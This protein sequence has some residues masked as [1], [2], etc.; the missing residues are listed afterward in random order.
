[1]P[2][3]L[4]SMGCDACVQACALVP[5]RVATAVHSHAMVLLHACM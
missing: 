3:L 1:M 2:A 4:K 5:F